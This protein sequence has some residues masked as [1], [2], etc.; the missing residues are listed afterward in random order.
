M[1]HASRAALS[2]A[3]CSAA[4]ALTL[5]LAPAATASELVPTESPA[6]VATSTAEPTATAEPVPAEPQPAEPTATPVPTLA[7]TA[8]PTVPPIAVPT[9]PPVVITPTEPPVT[10]ECYTDG[11]SP[12]A[13]D[14]PVTTAPTDDGRLAVTAPGGALLD[15]VDVLT[16][17][18]EAL[19]DGSWVAIAGDGTNADRVEGST[20]IY[21]V[22][23]EDESVRYVYRGYTGDAIGPRFVLATIDLTGRP[24]G[25]PHE[26]VVTT[27]PSTG[28]SSAHGSAAST[29]AT[30]T[31]T[32]ATLASTGVDSGAALGLAGLAMLAGAAAVSFTALRRRTGTAD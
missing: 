3:T 21:D 25:V 26:V 22:G 1:L 8:L 10:E 12:V 18:V 20:S 32:S 28:S 11:E 5:L 16:M 6:P 23:G 13:W 14:A 19:R 24:A 31:S 4:L 15:C 9:L 7:P 27:A 30:T 2:A 29:G 17:N